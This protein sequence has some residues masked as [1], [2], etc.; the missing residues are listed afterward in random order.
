M[1]SLEYQP[2]SSAEP[3]DYWGTVFLSMRDASGQIPIN[4]ITHPGVYVTKACFSNGVYDDLPT[5]TCISDLFASQYRRLIIDLYWDNINRQFSLCPVELPPLEGNSTAGYSVDSS[6]LFSITA[7]TSS[8]TPLPTTTA[9][10]NT[11]ASLAP[12]LEKRQSSSSSLDNT[13]SPISSPTEPITSTPTTTSD[14]AIP[15]STGATGGTLLQ[16]GP[17]LCS[18]D[19]NIGSIISLYNSYFEHTSDTISARLHFLDINLH[20]AAPFTDPSSPA[21]TPM[22]GRLPSSDQLVGAQFQAA[23]G[24]NIYTPQDLQDDRQDLNRS[25]F[26]D[27]YRVLTDANYF[28]TVETGQDGIVSTPDGWPGEDWALLTDSRRLLLSWDQIDPQMAEYDFQTESSSI[29]NATVLLRTP[30]V[31]LGDSGEVISGCYYHSGDTTIAQTNASWA[32]STIQDT[33][34]DTLPTL[35]QNLT[36]C[37]FSPVMNLTLDDLSVQ[38]NLMSYQ[39]FAQSTVFGWAPGQ[40]LDTSSAKKN[41]TTGSDLRC[42]VLDATGGF[43]GHWRMEPCEKSHRAACRIAGQPYAWRLSTFDVPYSAAP[44]ACPDSTSFG[45]PRTGLENTYLYR[46]ILNDTS[47]RD[48]DSDGILSGVWIN[49]NSINQPNCWVLGGPNATCPYSDF[50]EAEQQ[51]EILVPT[52][53]ALIILILTVLTILVKCN[54]NRRNSRTRRRGDNGW[55]YEGIPS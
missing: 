28:R 10:S 31:E 39:N 47:P 53:A 19:L 26:R 14:V 9:A 11:T 21:H 50:K 25:W 33:A 24:R 51:R 30:P 29:F 20:A 48:D 27:N 45:L 2:G 15:T 32:I 7:S 16:L 43:Q 3:D 1:T 23:L 49:F 52:I 5:Q 38:N 8:T 55:E 34:S 35:A 46:Q 36:A 37:G 40:P 12:S 6:A 42:A 17:Y 22:P 4:F 44:D 18:L 13:T 54:Q 41:G